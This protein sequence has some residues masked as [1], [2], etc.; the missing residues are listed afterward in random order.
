[1]GSAGALGKIGN[2]RAVL[3]LIE[4]LKDKSKDVR[5]EAKKALQAIKSEQKKK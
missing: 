5:E 2:K 4:V 3:A 1:M